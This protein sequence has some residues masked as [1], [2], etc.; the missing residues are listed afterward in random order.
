VDN[1][2][3]FVDLKAGTRWSA[4]VITLAQVEILTRR[5]AASGE[6][7]A[8]R[9]F[10]CSDGLIARDADITNVTQVLA[11]MIQNGDFTRILQRLED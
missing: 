10:W 6:P 9:Y 5:W 1:V 4:T 7:L 8:G 2:D 3:A 11:G